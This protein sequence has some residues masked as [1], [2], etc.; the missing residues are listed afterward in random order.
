LLAPLTAWSINA[1]RS[2]DTA[3][4]SVLVPLMGGAAVILVGLSLFDFGA[5]RAY[6]KDSGVISFDSAKAVALASVT[7][8]VD[9]LLTSDACL[10]PQVV[11]IATRK[12][13]AYYNLGLAWPDSRG[14]IDTVM[15]NQ[16]HAVFD[17]DAMRAAGVKYLVVDSACGTPWPVDQAMGLAQVAT[18]D[19]ADAAGAGTL[20]LWRLG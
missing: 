18:V 3:H 4:R 20:S 7:R 11:K 13:V 8:D 19:Y 16:R 12:P 10:D 9:G 6:V 2:V 5:F 1:Y 17:P 14:A 15:D